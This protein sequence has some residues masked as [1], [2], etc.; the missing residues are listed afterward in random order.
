[1]NKEKRREDALQEKKRATAANE[2]A[3]SWGAVIFTLLLLIIPL[4]IG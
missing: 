3:F 1:M 2:V 4:A